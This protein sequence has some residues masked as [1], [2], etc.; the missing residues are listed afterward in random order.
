MSSEI[1]LEDVWKI[2]GKPPNQVEA[3]RG[4]GLSVRKGE[5]LA[6]VGPSGS[7]KST[8]LHLVGGLDKPT[9]GRIIVAG[10]EISSIR[11]DYELSRYRNEVV[12]FVFQLF[13]LVPRLKVIDNVALPLVKRGLPPP[14]RRELALEALKLVGL[15]HAANKYPSQLSGGEQQR[16]A[17]ARAIVGKPR[18][19]LADEPTGNLDAA[20]SKVVIDL[21]TK[22][23][24]ELGVTVMMVTHN[25]ELVW[26]CDRVARMHLGRIAEIYMP[27]RYEELLR[28]FVKK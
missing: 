1:L 8:L 28:T 25:L 11:S 19:L 2:Y 14:E 10:K 27:D 4:V 6:V 22:L 23:N 9:R 18:V 7:G 3:V 15:E 20:N 17:I 12:G 5:F 24:K 16:V 13:Y 21:F 26:H